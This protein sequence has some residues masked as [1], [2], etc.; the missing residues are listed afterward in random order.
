MLA[1]RL[2]T[3]LP[4][5]TLPEAI[6][7]MRMHRVAGLTG[8][9]TAVVTPRPCRAPHPRIMVA[10]L[11][12]SSGPLWRLL[13][14]LWSPVIMRHRHLWAHGPVFSLGAAPLC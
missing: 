11:Y 2:T 13:Q 1:P 9:R 4:E 5:M 8:P 7:T 3:I 12:D 10:H 6:E 14:E